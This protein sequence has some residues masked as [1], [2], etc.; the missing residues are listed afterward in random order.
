MDPDPVLLGHLNP[1]PL[2][3]IRGSG[4]KDPIPNTGLYIIKGISLKCKTKVKKVKKG[5]N[6]QENK[7]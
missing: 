1:D 5:T 2:N 7:R 6:E 4:L 3:R